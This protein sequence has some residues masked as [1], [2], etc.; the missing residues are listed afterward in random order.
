[1]PAFVGMTEVRAFYAFVKFAFN[2]FN[3]G[4]HKGLYELSLEQQ[5]G[6]E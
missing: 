4:V 3:A 1:M 2:L 5:E 6:K